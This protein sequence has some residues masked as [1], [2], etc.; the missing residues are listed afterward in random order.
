MKRCG[1][2]EEVSSVFVASCLVVT[3]CVQVGKVA[4]LFNLLFYSVQQERHITFAQG[5]KNNMLRNINKSAHHCRSR[6]D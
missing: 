2:V 1:G 3:G 5:R 4:F 6:F